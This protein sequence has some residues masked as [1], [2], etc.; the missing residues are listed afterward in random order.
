[1]TRPMYRS[2][3]L[4]LGVLA[5]S[6]MLAPL[7]AVAQST[8]PSQESRALIP[9]GPLSEVAPDIHQLFVAIGLYE[10]LG[11]MSAEG[12]AAAPDLEAE[13]FPG[14]GGSA[15][16]ATTASIYSTER[17][18][19]RFEAAAPIDR[20]TPEFRATLSAF[21]DSALG[22]RIAE[23]EIAARRAFLDRAVEEA[24]TELAQRRAAEGHP[25]VAQLTRF[26]A[27]N[28]LV[29]RNVSGALNSNF[30]FYR[31]LSDGGAFAAPIPEEMM[32]AEVWAQEPEIRAETLDW[33]FAYQMLAYEDLSDAEMD[34][35]IALSES[36]AGQ[37]VNAILFSGFDGL[38][39][40]ISND[41]GRAAAGFI[42][43][44]DT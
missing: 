44:E 20:L 42:A 39:E 6:A 21:F 9:S 17:M 1:M 15:W 2:V 22:R 23:G 38:F 43:G 41:L 33:L 32:L 5:A 7:P 40:A 3:V 19:A 4:A 12:L 35:Y 11:I 27:V 14:K 13:F 34:A 8:N 24:A 31:A 18:I 25:R 36:P 28:D 10:V 29:E 16:M 30:A 26:I 37:A